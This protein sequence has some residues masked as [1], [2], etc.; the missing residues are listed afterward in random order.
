[1]K[2]SLFEYTSYRAYLKDR[3]EHLGPKS[4]LKRQAAQALGVHTTFISQAVLGKADLSLDQAERMNTFLRHSSEE[5]EFF[6]S[7]L[8]HDRAADDTLKKRYALKLEQK[9]AERAQIQKR[10]DK[11][12][13]L[14][15]EHQER[16]YS[17]HVYGLLHVLASIPKFRSREALAKATGQ[18]QETINGMIDF[19][20]SVGVL[21]T[22]KSQLVPGEG[23]IHLGRNSKHLRQHHTNWRMAAAQHLAF[24]KPTDLHYSLA[25]SCSQDDA[26]QIRES[27]LNHLKEMTKKIEASK[28]ENA[29]VY[30]FDFFEWI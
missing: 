8:I 26:I 11:T 29:Y 25:F 14:I 4:G 3:L 23:H 16:F 19:L 10:L 17:T 28:E 2:P 18:P 6:L 5:G 7:L 22:S 15:N 9:R 27:L 20:L 30:C 1:M 12:K 13:E 24:S 21:K